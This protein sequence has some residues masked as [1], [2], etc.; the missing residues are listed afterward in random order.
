[1]K[2]QVL[3]GFRDYGPEEMLARQRMLDKVRAVFESFGYLPLHTP[4]LEYAEILLGKYGDEGEKLLYQFQDHGG[5]Q[6]AL[7]YDLTVPLARYVGMNPNLAFPF[8]RYQIAP[9]WRAERP[10]KGRFR[11]FYQCD[12]DLV[13][14]NSPQAD[15]ECILVD[16]AVLTALGL[17]GFR[18]QINHRGFLDGLF[19]A[20]AIPVPLHVPV[21]R[22]LDKVDKVPTEEMAAMLAEPV[23]GQPGLGPEQASL[24]LSLS[25]LT[26]ANRARISRC[27]DMTRGNA[28]AEAALGRLAQVLEL[29]EAGIGPCD[30]DPD[31]EAA[32]VFFT[33]SVARGL[34]YYT[35]IVYETF[36]PPRYGV[37]SVMSGGR[38]DHLLGTMAAAEIPAVGISLGID[39]LLAA[40]AADGEASAA[41]S[42][43][44]L[45]CSLA[46]CEKAAAETAA[47][48]RAR[49]VAAGGPAV[50]E[51]PEP[52]RLKK[53]LEYAN[54]KGIPWVVI[55][56]P[57]EVGRGIVALRSMLN[58]EQRE[59]A[60]D[61]VADELVEALSRP[62]PRPAEVKP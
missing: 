10:Q 12:V 7:R 29:V 5:R 17:R 35:G 55:Q 45:V 59:V 41:A 51:Y 61:K 49:L 26:G 44:V 27:L 15:A 57:E 20:L 1:M 4:A 48:V 32:Q 25:A 43:G 56:G 30:A 8:R 34:D 47:G 46:G 6:V 9:V 18:I 42:T 16:R 19:A 60:K 13:G 14:I 3:K 53:Q 31:G 22:I 38:Y 52:T 36:L 23:A 33:P 21:L 50:E 28:Q 11:E 2:P 58:G 54:R 37:G 39:R 62:A 24:L 40:L